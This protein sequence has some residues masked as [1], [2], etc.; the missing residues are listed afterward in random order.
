MRMRKLRSIS[1]ERHLQ[2][3]RRSVDRSDSSWRSGDWEARWCWS[4]RSCRTWWDPK[5]EWTPWF[6]SA[7][8]CPD[9]SD[10]KPPKTKSASSPTNYA[11]RDCYFQISDFII[12]LLGKFPVSQAVV[13]FYHYL[14]ISLIEGLAI[15]IKINSIFK[16]AWSTLLL[17]LPPI[18]CK[19]AVLVSVKESPSMSSRHFCFSRSA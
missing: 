8:S 15:F 18:C 11:R 12:P 10:Q 17:F 7:Q 2:N 14:F 3:L 19:I 13:D 1:K 4:V 5:T 16:K 6:H 9:L